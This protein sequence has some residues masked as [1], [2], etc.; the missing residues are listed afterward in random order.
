MKIMNWQCPRG[1]C[2]GV[3]GSLLGQFPVG[4]GVDLCPRLLLEAWG[5]RWV[6]LLRGGVC[7]LWCQCRG[8]PLIGWGLSRERWLDAWGVCQ[9]NLLRGGVVLGVLVRGVGHLPGQVSWVMAWWVYKYPGSLL[10]VC[11]A[12]ID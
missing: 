7:K 6:I 8:I 3:M 1:R 2:W 4:R 10:R 12:L 5:I 11:F 9:G